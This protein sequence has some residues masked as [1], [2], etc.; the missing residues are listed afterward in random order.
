MY[1]SLILSDLMTVY[2]NNVNLSSS[3]CGA[4][5]AG[6]AAGAGI[7]YLLGGD[8]SAVAGTF[9]NAV[10]MISKSVCDGAKPSCAA[11]IAAAVDVGILG[12]QMY[13]YQQN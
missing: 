2:Q 10:S 12:Y 1:R 5:Y 9:A 4:G 7:A 13:L 6:C 3:D 8:E 11:Q